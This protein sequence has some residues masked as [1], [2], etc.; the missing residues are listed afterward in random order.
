MIGQFE[1]ADRFKEALKS[2]EEGQLSKADYHFLTSIMLPTLK[3]KE[4]LEM[5]EQVTVL[6][7]IIT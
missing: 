5:V 1:F 4:N 2:K 7:N 3:R 6:S